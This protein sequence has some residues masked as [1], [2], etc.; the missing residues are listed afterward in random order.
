M[1]PSYNA[2]YQA[3]SKLLTIGIGVK[4]TAQ[5][6]KLVTAFVYTFLPVSWLCALFAHCSLVFNA[7]IFWF[8][9]RRPILFKQTH[10]FAIVDPAAAAAAAHGST[11]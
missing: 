2:K 4:Y 3:K 9:G 8:N 10:R 7:R 11:F 1:A 5:F 6:V